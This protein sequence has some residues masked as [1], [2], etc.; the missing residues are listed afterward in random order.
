MYIYI[1]IYKYIHIYIY[2]YITHNL[3]PFQKLYILDFLDTYSLPS[4]LWI[5]AKTCQPTHQDE[6]CSPRTCES[7][8]W[9]RH[10]QSPRTLLVLMICLPWYWWFVYLGR[11][12]LKV[13]RY[14]W[15]VYLW[16]STL[17]PSGHMKNT[18]FSTT[19]DQTL[20]WQCSCSVGG[21]FVTI[22]RQYVRWDMPVT[23]NCVFLLLYFH[24]LLT[25]LSLWTECSWLFVLWKRYGWGVMSQSYFTSCPS[26][27]TDFRQTRTCQNW[28]QNV[29]NTFSDALVILKNQFGDIIS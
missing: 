27:R 17:N 14:W 20:S 10:I 2:I 25:L 23:I 26:K 19:R 12:T 22:C 29:A 3:N 7:R 6:V 8:H 1:C 24:V 15:F 13:T 4:I 5:P 18:M 21:F 28:P 11:S 16:R 9:I